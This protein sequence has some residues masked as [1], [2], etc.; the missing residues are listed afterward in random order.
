M[1]TRYSNEEIVADARYIVNNSEQEEDGEMGG[2]I[3]S[4]R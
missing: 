2:K 3:P 4:D 1:P